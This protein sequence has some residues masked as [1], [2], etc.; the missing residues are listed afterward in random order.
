MLDHEFISIQS[1]G[2]GYVVETYSTVIAL[3]GK[4]IYQVLLSSAP[5]PE[6]PR[7]RTD[8][9]N[10][11]GFTREDLKKVLKSRGV[12]FS[13]SARKGELLL[14]QVIITK[15]DNKLRAEIPFIECGCPQNEVT[16]MICLFLV[17][18]YKQVYDARIHRFVNR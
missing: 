16:Q 1:Q 5:D 14:L 13:S 9:E 17:C 4:W 8:I 2:G 3:A 15:N 6:L 11:D 7:V 12:A 18:C 10:L